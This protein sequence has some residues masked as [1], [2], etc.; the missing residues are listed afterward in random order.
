LAL[1]AGSASFSLVTGATATPPAQTIGVQ[2]T[3]T[4]QSVSY[5]V[6]VSPAAPW[7]NVTSGPATPSSLNIAL[8]SQALTLPAG[9]NQTTVTL[10]CIST[11]CAGNTRLMMKRNASLGVRDHSIPGK[12]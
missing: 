6:G 8:T 5:T 10:T 4:A 7:L 3:N 12:A 9:S 11:S 1:Q 2:S